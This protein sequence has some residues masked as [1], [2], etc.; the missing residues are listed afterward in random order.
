MPTRLPGGSAASAAPARL[1]IASRGSARVGMATIARPGASSAGTSF[2]LCTARSIVA[3]EQRLLD[4]LDPD[5]LAAEI[6]HR[7]G[8]HAVALR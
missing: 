7:P 1:T 3:R 2:R 6:D 5:A 4:L 8:L